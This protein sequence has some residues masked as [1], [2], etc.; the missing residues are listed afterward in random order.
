MPPS[1]P[2]GAPLPALLWEEE[3]WQSQCEWGR[4]PKSEKGRGSN[5][6]LGSKGARGL[7]PPGALG[8]CKPLYQVLLRLG[9]PATC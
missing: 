8:G 9:C 6:E 5:C 1:F 3:E 4:G 2:A 7:N